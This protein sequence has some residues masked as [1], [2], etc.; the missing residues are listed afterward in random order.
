[1]KQ[2]EESA[3]IDSAVPQADIERIVIKNANLTIV[4]D[5]PSLT[6]DE[7]TRMTEEMGGYVVLANLYQQELGDARW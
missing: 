6:L 7:I 2:S 5:D 1:V 4:V 3:K